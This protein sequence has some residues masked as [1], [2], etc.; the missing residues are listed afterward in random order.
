VQ[1]EIE[2]E[3]GQ[4]FAIAGLL[5]NRFNET[6]DKIPG[7]GNIP[8]LGKLFQSRVLTKSNSEL[9]IMVTPELVRPVP[10][11]QARPEIPMPKPFIKDT[12][13]EAPRNPGLD[14]TGPVPVKPERETIPL[15]ELQKMQ[16]KEQ[17]PV[18]GTGQPTLLL[19][20]M[21]NPAGGQA[22]PGGTPAPTG[23]GTGSGTSAPPA[24]GTGTGQ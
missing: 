19:P 7:L 15:E 3:N 9:L 20:L 2:L 22:A 17:G 5:D 12:L 14:V 23:T 1:T 16:Q 11:G 13:K 21:M 8:L 24:A 18:P 10:A 6:I 4:S